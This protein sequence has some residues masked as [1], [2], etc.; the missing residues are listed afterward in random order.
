M[1]YNDILFKA[2]ND[3]HY[4]TND[5][6]RVNLK[7][8][9]L[10]SNKDLNEYLRL[11]DEYETNLKEVL[12]LKAFNSSSIY[13]YKSFELLSYSN[14]Y[15]KYIYNDMNNDCSIIS[16]NYDEMIL[17]RVASELEGT[18]KI[19]GINTTRKKILDIISSKSITDN[20]E[21][22]IYNMYE[23]YNFI[24]N[25]PSFNQ[26]NLFKL[27]NILSYNSLKIED[28]PKCFY[29][30][31]MVVVGGHDGCDVS[32]IKSCMDSLFTY[33]NNNLDKK[34]TFL[35]FIAHYY[36]LYVHPYFDYNGRTARMVS[37]WISILFGGDNILPIYISE[38]INDDKANYYKAIDN[39]RNSHN[40]LTYFLTYMY[41]L[42]NIYY[43]TY[44]NINEI[45]KKLALFGEALSNTEIYYLKRIII[46]R[47][48]GWFNY[49][50]FI[51]FCNLDI[52]KQGALKILNRFLSQG[53]LISKI[54]SKNEKVFKI[55][56]DFIEF[57]YR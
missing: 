22:I 35:P 19:E 56:D 4:F 20:N 41:K 55:N 14:D 53:I 13:Y 18:L 38:A 21:Q 36:I 25:K 27:Y 32:L 16:D 3:E 7:Y 30:D 2:L 12:P 44:R 42:S 45:K 43:T 34:S 40:D 46:K 8:G 28:M 49:K 11:K 57:E 51:A 50:G 9:Y 23:G 24:K 15:L 54:N 10:L 52:S 48:Q 1:N 29:R 47:N 33:V 17:S 31:D 37:L 5:D 39:S 26:E 6:L